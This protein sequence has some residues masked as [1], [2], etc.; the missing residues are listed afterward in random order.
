MYNFIKNRYYAGLITNKEVWG[1]VP[2][3]L[4]EEQAFEICGPK[5]TEA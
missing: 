4:T 3:Y 5:P 2:K 1:Y